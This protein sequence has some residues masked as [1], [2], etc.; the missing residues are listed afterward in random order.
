M[1]NLRPRRSKLSARTVMA[2]SFHSMKRAAIA[3]GAFRI[4]QR[5]TSARLG[6]GYNP[7]RL[8]GGLSLMRV[9]P[10]IGALVMSAGATV[11]ATDFLTEGVDNARTGWVQDEKIFTTS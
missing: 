3:G 1:G 2:I 8:R 6:A 9:R 4:S 10:L 7:P 5:G 11:C